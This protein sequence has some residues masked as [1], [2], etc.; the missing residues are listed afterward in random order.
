MGR[1]DWLLKYVDTSQRGI[2]VAP[3]FNP[4][5]PKADGHN[6]LVLDVFDKERL[7]DNA[8]K[9]PLIEDDRIGSIEEVDIVGDASRI[10]EVVEREGLTGKMHYI[11]SSHNFEHLP[12]PIL[13]LRGAYDALAPAG[14]LSMA[15]PDCRATFDFYRMPTSL[16]D[17]LAAYHE[18]RQQPSPETMFDYSSAMALYQFGEKVEPGYEL[19]KGVPRRFVPERDL[20]TAYETYVRTKQHEHEYKDAHCSVFFPESLRLL[21]WDLHKLQLVDFEVLEITKTMGIEFYVHLRKSKTKRHIPNDEFFAQRH[22][23][24]L[25]VMRNIG[26][27]PYPRGVGALWQRFRENLKSTFRRK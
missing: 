6:V 20:V 11:V 5:L 13:F 9:D 14:V 1:L 4:A 3:Y 27:A 19:G 7:L 23:M 2:E 26:M 15:V 8:R 17:W 24:M 25:A 18:D 10:G 21:L 12:N 16:C 22:E